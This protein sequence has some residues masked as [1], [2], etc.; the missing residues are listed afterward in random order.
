VV[1]SG[2]TDTLG[3]RVYTGGMITVSHIN[4]RKSISLLVAR[5]VVLTLLFMGLTTALAMPGLLLPQVLFL[6]TVVLFAA[7]VIVLNAFQLIL[8][9][10]VI[11]GWLTEYYEISEDTV[12][13]RSGIVFH[14]EEVYRIRHLTDASC[15]QT[16][17]GE[18][19]NFGTITLYDSIT[20][21]YFKIAGIHNPKRCFS[22]LNQ[23]LSNANMRKESIGKPHFGDEDKDA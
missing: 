15:E 3:Y 17:L 14:R 16:F 8:A 11:L 20:M 21:K 4:V 23:A 10:M 7:A 9:V 2:V 5:L 13:H 6:D 22:I 19:F 12:T 1:V 18:M